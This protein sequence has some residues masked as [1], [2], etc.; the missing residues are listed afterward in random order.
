M[1]VSFDVIGFNYWFLLFFNKVNT[2]ITRYLSAHHSG[3][4]N[5]LFWEICSVLRRDSIA[6]NY[7]N[8]ET[9]CIPS[10]NLSEIFELSFLFQTDGIRARSRRGGGGRKKCRRRKK[11][12]SEQITC[13]L[14]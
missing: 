5:Y 6:L 11:C 12:L 2:A 8:I 13:K 14:K 7:A 10:F 4:Y 1:N 3:P 9:L